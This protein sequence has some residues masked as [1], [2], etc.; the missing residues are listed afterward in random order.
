MADKAV[1]ETLL[2]KHESWNSPEWNPVA[3]S[4]GAEHDA[5]GFGTTE[6]F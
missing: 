6:N 2:K 5:S 4:L 3:N 1:S